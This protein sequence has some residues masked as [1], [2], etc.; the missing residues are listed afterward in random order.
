[1]SKSRKLPVARKEP[2]AQID[3][4]PR[5]SSN[6]KSLQ[7]IE[8]ETAVV[9]STNRAEEMEVAKRM[10]VKATGVED[11]DLAARIIDQVGRTQALWPY[12]NARE[13][14]QVA[15]ELLQEI[16][17]QSVT[18]AML[19]TQM[20]GVHHAALSFLHRAALPD[21]SAE[22]VNPNVQ[23]AAR[24]MRLFNEQLE[25]MEKLKGKRGQ[26]TVRVEHVHIHG[27]QAIVGS[28]GS[29]QLKQGEGGRNEKSSKTP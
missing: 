2:V 13:A 26:Q 18:E 27:G 25:A 28:F 3:N 23:T 4:V 1:M 21:K 19:A 15:V 6:Q 7:S 20:I 12:G 11:L 29:A 8:A 5:E 9:R 10:L 14:F 17:P 22:G 16:H 24:L